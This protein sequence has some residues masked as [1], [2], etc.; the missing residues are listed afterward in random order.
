[1]VKSAKRILEIAKSFQVE[2]TQ[3]A[4]RGGEN[5]RSS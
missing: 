1:M 5:W 4:L 3:G 2:K